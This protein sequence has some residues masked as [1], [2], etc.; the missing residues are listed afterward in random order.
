MYYHRQWR[1]SVKPPPFEYQDP[2]SLDD[3]M[4]LLAEHGEEGKVLAGGQSL[5][6][7]LNFRLAQPSVLIDVNRVSELS[8]LRRRDGRLQIGAL[9]RQSRLERSPVTRENWGLLT[10]AVGLV[11][12]QQIRSRGTVGG[13]AAHADPTAELPVALTA[14][15][16]RFHV[17]SRSGER[18]L[19][20]FY[21]GPPDTRP[22][23][24]ELLPAIERPPLPPHARTAFAE[25]APTHGSFAIAGVAVVR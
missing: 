1:R 2:R 20:D 15:G 16:A 6:P 17:R 8:Y 4:G 5:V 14:L 23:P 18:V 21:N 9:C 13:S 22:D 10:E 24:A 7:L 3:A 11:A 12:H 19:G 25:Y